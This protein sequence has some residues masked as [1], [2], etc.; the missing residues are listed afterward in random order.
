MGFKTFLQE[1]WLTTKRVGS[2]KVVEI[3]I[4]TEKSEL[5]E[6]M[7]MDGNYNS[8]KL[9]FD[10]KKKKLYLYTR[11]DVEHRVVAQE[12]GIDTENMVHI[13]VVG[14]NKRVDVY[15]LEDEYGLPD[16]LKEPWDKYGLPMIKKLL[17][18]YKIQES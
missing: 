11:S 3:F 18:G 12:L 14:D 2:N 9:I 5:K 17:P 1:K 4:D 15:N 13:Y 10:T 7:A 8:A 16:Y 6:V